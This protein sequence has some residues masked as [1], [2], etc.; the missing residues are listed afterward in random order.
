MRDL[1]KLSPAGRH[2]YERLTMDDDKRMPKDAVRK[3]K[4]DPCCMEH[5]PNKICIQV[6]GHE[7]GA[8]IEG[9]IR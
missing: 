5:A 6:Y 8:T 4:Y 1:T 2:I 3:S 7:L 9:S